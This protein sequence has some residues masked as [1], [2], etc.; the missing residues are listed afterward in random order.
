MLEYFY[1]FFY[2]YDTYSNKKLLNLDKQQHF[3]FFSNIN[4]DVQDKRIWL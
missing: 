2:K 3:H 4:F 1:L